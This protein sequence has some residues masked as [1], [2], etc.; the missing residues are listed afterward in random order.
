MPSIGRLTLRRL[1]KRRAIAGAQLLA[2][3]LAIGVPLSLQSVTTVAGNA[4]YVSAI[5]VNSRDSLVTITTI[6][7][8]TEEKYQITQSEAA[9]A[10]SSSVGNRLER[11]LEFGRIASFSILTVNGK[12]YGSDPPAP[13][14]LASYYPA[15]DQHATLVSGEWPTAAAANQKVS[16]ALSEAGS[17]LY[18]LKEGDVA[19]LHAID[20]IPVPPPVCVSVSGTWKPR[21]ASDPFWLGGPTSTEMILSSDGY[22][23]LQSQVPGIHSIAGSIYRPNAAQLTVA[24]AP[25]LEAGVVRLRGS[26][27][28][29]GNGLRPA[30]Q[31]GTSL[32]RRIRDF[33]EGTAVNQFPIQIVAVAMVCVVL[34]G[35][36]FV[37][38]SF[39]RSQEQQSTLWRVRGWSRARL[40][41]F[42]GLH[43]IA[44]VIPAVA[45][46]IGIALLSTWLVAKGQGA[47]F[48]VTAPDVLTNFGQTL[49]LSLIG[50]L[51]LCLGLAARFAWRTVGQMRRSLG[52]PAPVAWWRYRNADLALGLLAIPVLIEASLRGQETVRSAVSGADPIGLVLPI[53]GLGGLAVAELRLLPLA[54][55]TLRQ[56]SRGVPARLTSWRI[57]GQPAEHA[58]V[59]MLLALT[60]GVGV[61]ASVYASTQ[62][63]N[64]VDRVAYATGADVRI[65]ME[66]VGSPA[67]LRTALAGVPGVSAVTPILRKTVRFPSSGDTVI[68]FGVD[69]QTYLKAAWSRPGLT[70]PELG[71]ALKSL[72]GQP[73]FAN[74]LGEPTALRLWVRGIDQPATL[75]ALVADA[76]GQSTTT[77][78][79]AITFDDWRQ[80][81]APLTFSTPPTYP[82]QLRSLEAN[83]PGIGGAIALSGFEA[84]SADGATTI[85]NFDHVTGWWAR[86][87][88]GVMFAP[89]IK[90]PRGDVQ[91]LEVPLPANGS[92]SFYPPFGAEPLPMLISQQ[93]LGR[94]GLEQGESVPILV[95][96]NEVIG[97]LVQ[98]VDYVPTLYPADDFVVVPLDRA[99]SRFAAAGD[100]PA[101]PNELWLSLKPAAAAQP[102]TL[103]GSSGINFVLYRASEQSVAL[104]DPILIQLRANLAIGFASALGLAVLGFAVH[105]LLVTRRRLS[106][107]AILLANGLDP[108]DIHRGIA[109]EQLTVAVFGLFAGVALAIVA[110]VVLLPSLQLGNNPQDVTPPTLIHLDGEQLAAAALVLALAM[111]VL[112][113][114][115][116]RAGSTVNVVEELRRLG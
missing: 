11:I 54:A 16:V 86:D 78:F 24:Q 64:V 55:P 102:L 10:V 19:C 46:A 71:P 23:S 31:V 99:L 62:T 41:V 51:I 17:A 84:V 33:L 59:A 26:K 43:L 68:A 58:G 101:I 44:L 80:M 38:Q 103:T 56:V 115:T 35:L 110:I 27:Q 61:F 87:S 14:L 74:L 48:S 21:G 34:Y 104:N 81:T 91:G 32:D 114:F 1:F 105:F 60:L 29:A 79:G 109:L 72:S 75:A 88:S 94:F 5:D 18:G 15:L 9:S 95:N 106:E 73:P 22:W 49:G 39:L 76:K 4:G 97:K 3:A 83:S 96:G 100:E 40:G 69:L 8:E 108:D 28:F 111:I 89:G 45:L 93:T 113:M 70:T 47:A 107:H 37:S 52:R 2:M 25:V 92:L 36:A 90:R 57:A 6:G 82:L 67:V 7:A 66:P 30:T 53:L 98:A 13:S 63:S 65:S 112:A 12:E 50:V 77:S 116:R 42:L 20:V 85:E